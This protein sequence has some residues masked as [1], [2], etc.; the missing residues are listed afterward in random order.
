ML[1]KVIPSPLC[2]IIDPFMKHT[3]I[4]II[5]HAHTRPHDP[6][7]CAFNKKDETQHKSK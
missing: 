2:S 5:L 1:K 4:P 3:R 6:L 7:V